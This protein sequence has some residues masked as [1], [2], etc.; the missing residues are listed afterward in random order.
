MVM[1]E[2]ICQLYSDLGLSVKDKSGSLYDKRTRVITAVV[3]EI[4]NR[5]RRIK[6]I[7]YLPD[8]K[9][10]GKKRPLLLGPSNSLGG[11]SVSTE[12]HRESGKEHLVWRL[13]LPPEWWM[14]REELGLVK[15]ATVDDIRKRLKDWF[16]QWGRG[17]ERHLDMNDLVNIWSLS[18]LNKPKEAR[19]QLIGNLLH[20]AGHRHLAH[21]RSP[22]ME[23]LRMAGQLLIW[24]AIAGIATW[25][26][27]RW[28][29][30]FP[31]AVVAGIAGVKGVE[32]AISKR[33]ER[34]ADAFAAQFKEGR[35]GNIYRL[36]SY[37]DQERFTWGKRWYYLEAAERLFS[38]HP[39]NYQ[40]LRFFEAAKSTR[41]LFGGVGRSPSRS[42]VADE[43]KRLNDD[44]QKSQGLLNTSQSI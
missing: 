35:K 24:L 39:T 34:A 6:P 44:F 4:I 10:A 20:E 37:L 25:M 27:C 14:T 13:T 16:A 19:Y 26:G 17:W 2:V 15:E 28:W 21:Q 42:S 30:A 3:C 12:T 1:Y 7:V 33:K 41:Q 29:V 43:L 11:L 38:S 18:V 5:T 9:V 36:H 23:R 32:A 40:R 8:E 31:A 22:M